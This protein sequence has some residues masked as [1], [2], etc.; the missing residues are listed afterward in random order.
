MSRALDWIALA[1][2]VAIVMILVRP[3]SPLPDLINAIGNLV[4]SVAKQATDTSG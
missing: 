2:V 4:V 3:S 1:V